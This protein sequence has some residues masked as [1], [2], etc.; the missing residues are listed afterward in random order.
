MLL[1]NQMQS[2]VKWL[3]QYKLMFPHQNLKCFVILVIIEYFLHI[4]SRNENRKFCACI[5]LIFLYL[6]SNRFCWKWVKSNTPKLFHP[7]ALRCTSFCTQ[8]DFV[9]NVVNLSFSLSRPGRVF[10][11]ARWLWE[12][13]HGL[14]KPHWHLYVYLPNWNDPTPWWGGLYGW[15]FVFLRFKGLKVV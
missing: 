5:V 9:C 2:S 14:Q 6:L 12:Q 11:G 3:E 13:G 8:P 15:V 7:F 1:N 4:T 10:G